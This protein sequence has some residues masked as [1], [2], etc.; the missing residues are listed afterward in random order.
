MT[1]STR[2]VQRIWW[3]ALAVVLAALVTAN[4][5]G[6]AAG[7]PGF[8][9]VSPTA[10]VK[11]TGTISGTLDSVWV[12]RYEMV[13]YLENVEG[14]F[15]AGGEQAVIDQKDKMFVPHVLPVV[16]GAMVRYVNHDDTKHNVYMVQPDETEFNLGTGMADW[17]REHEMSQPGVYVHRCNVHD[18]MSA[19]VIVL[20]NPH[21]VLIPKVSGKTTE[22][23]LEGVPP[24]D[25]VLRVWCERFY[26]QPGH[27][28]NRAWNVTVEGGAVSTVDVK[29]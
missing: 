6:A 28:F 5:S 11:E 27:K 18:E 8:T 14:T 2:I 26:D 17:S 25:Y 13:I 19:Y 9:S 23:T 20:Q 21:F 7:P 22:F 16:A 15:E 3:V 1:R 29:P 24:G 12:R 4:D 10:P